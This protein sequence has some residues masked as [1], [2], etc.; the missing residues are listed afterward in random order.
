M[1][2]RCDDTGAPFEVT[3]IVYQ[4]RPLTPPGGHVKVAVYPVP[5]AGQENETPTPG[6]PGVPGAV[7]VVAPFAIELVTPAA[8]LEVTDTGEAGPAR[9]SGP[10][11]RTPS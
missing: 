4:S 3:V 6:C 1:P 9:R 8:A 11:Q 2:Q 7:V 10:A 5:G